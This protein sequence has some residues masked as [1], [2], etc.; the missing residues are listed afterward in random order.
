MWVAEGIPL[1][2]PLTAVEALV[3]GLPGACTAPRPPAT[4]L[5]GPPGPDSEPRRAPSS[6]R[7]NS[8]GAMSRRAMAAADALQD[9]NPS[10]GAPTRNK[11]SANGDSTAPTASSSTDHNSQPSRPP[12]V[13]S[14]LRMALRAARPL[15]IFCAPE[16]AVKRSG[17]AKFMPSCTGAGQPRPSLLG[18]MQAGPPRGPSRLA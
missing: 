18:P 13:S 5:V 8:K 2:V 9:G 12:T 17:K 11:R 3:P 7:R 14:T 15:R 10:S 6:V 16:V 4:R 1:L